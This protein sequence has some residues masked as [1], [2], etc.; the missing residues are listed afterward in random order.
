[1]I[2][3]DIGT[4]YIKLA[5]LEKNGG[6]YSIRSAVMRL[7]P[8]TGSGD[9][10]GLL[11]SSRL[12]AIA[13]ES[14][15]FDK[16][17]AASIGGSQIIARN[18][19]LA[20]LGPE[21][22][23]GAVLIEA[24]QS[25]SADLATMY[26]D[27]QE[28]ATIERGRKDVLFIAVPSVLVDKQ[29]SIIEN[30]GLNIELVDIDSFAAANCYAALDKNA[31]GQTVVLMNIG[32][33]FTNIAVID[34]GIVRFVRNVSFGGVNI[35]SEIADIYKIPAESAEEIKK[36]PDLWKGLGLNIKNVL[37]KSMPDL[38]EAVYR[39]MEYCVGRK[40]IINVDKI[41]I[42]GGT[43]DIDGIDSFIA[44]ALGIVSEKWNPL[45][46]IESGEG[47]KKESGGAL[48]VA[49]GLAVREWQKS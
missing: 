47:S 13:K 3:I 24:R 9:K 42:T 8:A 43:S 48:S 49:L 16:R 21:E 11:L 26:S 19:E 5:S 40:K 45:E 4:K 6:D 1:V 38:L 35:T 7:N 15:P 34:S 31:P 25:V 33:S 14:F 17:A 41:L 23:E 32:H 37:R 10:Q 22:M 46:H 39:S 36:R 44:E 20:P 28:L 29:V 30:S 12:R 27:F 18:F 2:G